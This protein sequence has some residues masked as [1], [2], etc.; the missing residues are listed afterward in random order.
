MSLLKKALR[1]PRVREAACRIAALYVRLV[2]A[3]GRWREEGADIRDRCIGSGQPFIVCFWH[4]QLLVMAP[5]WPRRASIK[6][7]IS[8]HRDG[9]LIARTVARFGI[10]TIPGSSSKGG[11]R[12]LRMMARA[13]EAGECVGV[14]PDGPRGP[15]MR[16]SAG[17]VH[18]ARLAGVR[19][20]P[21][22][23][24]AKRRCVLRSWDR[25]IVPLPFTGGIVRWG[26]PIE[27]DG[28]DSEAARRRI[29]D[30]L[31]EMTRELE[32]RLGHVPID[33]DPVAADAPSA[34]G[35]SA[36]AFAG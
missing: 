17:V 3:T 21:A 20:V 31:N 32:T 22:A 9:Q 8:P 2:R 28:A 23:G 7:L 29:E 16:A 1:D 36:R 33:P 24:V 12:A 10:G 6:F 19:V 5:F 15:R 35:A 13:L 11:S 18:A 27:V 25:F 34:A 4:G 26:E 14:T 30:A